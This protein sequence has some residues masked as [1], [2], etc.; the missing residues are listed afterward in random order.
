[1]LRNLSESKA[2]VS[3]MSSFKIVLNKT[4]ATVYI[5]LDL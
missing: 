5:K 2:V 3:A 1:M 4:Y